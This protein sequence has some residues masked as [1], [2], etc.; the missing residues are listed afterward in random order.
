MLHFFVILSVC[1]WYNADTNKE[2]NTKENKIMNNVDKIRSMSDIELYELFR[3]IYNAGLVDG[4]EYAR[5]A[6]R[7]TRYEWTLTWLAR[8][9]E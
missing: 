5:K 1:L 2:T 7:F 8:E 6:G 9:A 3:D 4:F